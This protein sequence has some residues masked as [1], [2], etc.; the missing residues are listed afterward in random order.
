[1]KR[2]TDNSEAVVRAYEEARRNI[3]GDLRGRALIAAYLDRDLNRRLMR[4]YLSIL[5]REGIEPF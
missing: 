3:L 1:M 4:E 2:K 5:A